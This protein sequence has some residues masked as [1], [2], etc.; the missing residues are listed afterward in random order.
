[1]TMW[2]NCRF[3]PSPPASVETRMRAFSANCRWTRRRSSRSI[4]PLR[5]TTEKPCCSRKS[6]SMFCVGTNSVKIRYFNSGLFSSR[7]FSY[8]MS[9]SVSARASGPWA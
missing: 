9:S 6:R 1:M 4:D 3:R 2:A 5:H 8:R 7:W